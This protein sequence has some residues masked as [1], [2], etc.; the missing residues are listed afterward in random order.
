MKIEWEKM[1]DNVTGI[2]PNGDELTYVV[3]QS[4]DGVKLEIEDNILKLKDGIILDYD[5][6]T[7]LN[8]FII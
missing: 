2:D 6:D 5:Q 8:F 4:R 1:I 3:F 7:N